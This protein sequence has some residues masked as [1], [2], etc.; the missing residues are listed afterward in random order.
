MSERQAI[1]EV[2]PP[3]HTFGSPGN[4]DIEIVE[5]NTPG[6]KRRQRLREELTAKRIALE[7]VTDS[8]WNSPST[9][10][11]SSG[12]SPGTPEWNGPASTNRAA[13][14]ATPLRHLANESQFGRWIISFTCVCLI[15]LLVVLMAKSRSV[16]MLG[17][18]LTKNRLT[19]TLVELDCRM[20]LIRFAEERG[21]N[22]RG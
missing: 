22:R 12:A 13:T 3:Y 20:L 10:I 4:R 16:N 18:L 7:A 11:L 2:H 14:V 9:P 1:Y 21:K 6:E 15:F 5:T 8:S 19:H 17:V